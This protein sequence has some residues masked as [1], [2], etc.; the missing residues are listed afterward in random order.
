MSRRRRRTG[1]EGLRVT[2]A[3]AR[4][5]VIDGVL[6]QSSLDALWNYFQV[7]EFRRVEA[8][9]LYGHWALDDAAALR[10]PAVGYGFDLEVRYPSKTPIDLVIDAVVEHSEKFDEVLG[11]RGEGWELFSGFAQVYARGVGLLWHRD[12]PD[13]AGSYTFYAHPEWN[14]SWGGE[15]LLLDD[16]AID[17]DSGVYFHQLRGEG[18]PWQPHLDNEDA[19]AL[20]MAHGVGRMVLPKPNRLVVIKGGTPH[21]VAK[22]QPAAGNH[23]RASVSGF[24]K[25][26]S[27][28]KKFA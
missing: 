11:P 24:F 9:G 14:V 16:D 12:S 13:N 10:G 27:V 19:S 6:P 20:L 21:C 5:V 17:P 22:V 18:K 8:L 1:T 2:H 7:Q 23:C 4:V 25:R 26:K 28:S 15:L 3:D